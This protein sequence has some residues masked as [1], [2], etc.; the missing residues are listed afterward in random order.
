MTKQP[1]PIAQI[2]DQFAV[3]RQLDAMDF[4][5]LK[6]R[7]VRMIINNRP[8]DEG[9]AP[10]ISAHDAEELAKA[11]G[12][13][14]LHLPVTGLDVTDDEPVEAFRTAIA[15]Y[16]GFIVAH[17]A[18][19]MRSLILWAMSEAG[20]RPTGEIMARAE[21][22]GYDLDVVRE[23]IEERSLALLAHAPSSQDQL[24]LG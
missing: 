5:I 22:A 2:T 10:Y 21:A 3:A 6:A 19:G 7:G 9:D 11:H 4:A 13:D 23:E 16:D 18:V 15:D 17:C 8:D 1:T 20:R 14:Y 24:A 12:I